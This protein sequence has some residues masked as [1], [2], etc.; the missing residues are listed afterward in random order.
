L[1]VARSHIID[2]MT[3]SPD[4]VDGRTVHQIDVLADLALVDAC[5]RRLRNC[6]PTG[7]DVPGPW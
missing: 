4:W 3:R 1:G 6:R 7:I 2:L 5:A